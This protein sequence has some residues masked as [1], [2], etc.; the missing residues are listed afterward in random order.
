MRKGFYFDQTRCT[1][2]HTCLIACKD[3]H[4]EDLKTEPAD[5]I[6]VI[7]VEKGK[8][9]DLSLSYLAHACLHCA[10]PACVMACPVDAYTKREEDGIVVVDTKLCVGA[11]MCGR[12][13][14]EACPYDVPNFGT[15]ENPKVQ[16]CDLCLDRWAEGKKPV[17]VESCPTRAID[18]GFMDELKEKY[19]KIT[20][21]EGF[22]YHETVSPSIIFKPKTAK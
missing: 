12:A 20:E 8:Y 18:A 7:S 21:A 2:C 15:E 16:K 22:M 3:W 13:C 1:G 19:G 10:K 5:W 11:D 9:P 6:K 17:C 4:E 14:Q